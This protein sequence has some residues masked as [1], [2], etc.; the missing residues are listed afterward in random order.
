MFFYGNVSRS[1]SIANYWEFVIFILI[2]A[3]VHGLYLDKVL[4]PL[5]LKEG[6]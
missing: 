4:T 3:L 5:M 6:W 2:S 1:F